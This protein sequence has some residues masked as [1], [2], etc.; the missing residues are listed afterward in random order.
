MSRAQSFQGRHL[1]GIFVCA[2]VTLWERHENYQFPIAMTD[3]NLP[4]G[5]NVVVILNVFMYCVMGGKNTTILKT[6]IDER[7]DFF[8]QRSS[9]Q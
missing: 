6:M 3:L 4:F 9:E 7:Q 1:F 5:K 8:F 2:V